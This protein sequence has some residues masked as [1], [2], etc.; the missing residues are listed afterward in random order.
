[1]KKS[2]AQRDKIIRFP[3]ATRGA[4]MIYT[5]TFNPS[6][7]YVVDLPELRPGEINRT[8]AEAIYPGGKGINVS[9]VL[10][11]LGLPSC[12]LG[13]I[14]GFTGREIERLSK[15][16]GAATNFIQLP[17]GLS[18]INVK[19][20]AGR[21]TAL[22]GSGPA[23]TPAA[24]QELFR[25]L[26][27]LHQDDLLVLAGSIPS[28]MPTD[29][30]EQILKQLAPQKIKIVVDATG[31]LLRQVLPYHPFLIKPNQDELGEL[32]GVSITTET[33]VIKY[34]RQLQEEGAVNVLIS[35]GAQGALLIGADK[36]VYRQAAP[37]GRLVNSVGAGDSTVAGFIA[38]YLHD[39]NLA[40]ALKLGVCTGSASAFHDWLASK[41]DIEAALQSLEGGF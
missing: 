16:Y 1:M 24:L 25:Q 26:A 19:I 2:C 34:A 20:R 21:E 23:I 9:L 18:R 13:F 29:I 38:G 4:I 15:T 39:G 40:A 37:H 8:A 41:A 6:L 3:A 30:Y 28:G 35:L 27:T 36:K 12:M 7:D 31:Q 17:D 22:N 14:A 11:Q 32:F 10:K 33:D 5:V